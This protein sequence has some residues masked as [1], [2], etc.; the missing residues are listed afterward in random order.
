MLQVLSE[1]TDRILA[2]AHPMSV[3][4]RGGH[5]MNNVVMHEVS[6]QTRCNKSANFLLNSVH[7]SRR[8]S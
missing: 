8:K 1:K 7:A 4:S 2:S 5:V 3:R 6:K